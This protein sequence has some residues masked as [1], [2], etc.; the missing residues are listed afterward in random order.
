M[1]VEYGGAGVS[2][3]TTSCFGSPR[4]A[5][6]H[7]VMF[8]GGGPAVP[9]NYE[10]ALAAG[11]KSLRRR[12]AGEHTVSAAVLAAAFASEW[13]LAPM[14]VA[15]LKRELLAEQRRLEELLRG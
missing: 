1:I 10:R 3:E 12:A 2:R 13:K 4:Q 14:N 15:K 6:F 9:T 5:I 8:N 11:I 7:G